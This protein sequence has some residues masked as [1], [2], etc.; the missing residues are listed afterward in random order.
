MGPL[1]H[2]IWVSIHVSLYFFLKIVL[3]L[4]IICMV[5]V[6]GVNGVTSRS[7]GDK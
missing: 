6:A 3:N 5:S 2:L 7:N 1:V 4:Y